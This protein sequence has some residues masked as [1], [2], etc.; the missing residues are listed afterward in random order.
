MHLG[1][2]VCASVCDHSWAARRKHNS[3]PLFISEPT[4]K[5]SSETLNPTITYSLT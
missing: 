3:L 5:V 1:C 4:Y 2:V